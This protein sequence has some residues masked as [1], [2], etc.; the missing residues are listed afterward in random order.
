[1][2]GGLLFVSQALI[3]TWAAQGRIDFVG[4]V[5]TLLAGEGAGR[6]YELE[7]AVRFLKVLGVEK[8]PH[9]L[10]AKVKPLA[11]LRDL[12]AEA[13]ESSVI[14]GDVAYDVEQGFLAEASAIQAAVSAPIPSTPPPETPAGKAGHVEAGAPLASP[15]PSRPAGLPKDLEERRK[16]A[17]ALARFL[18]DN[19]S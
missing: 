15:A 5:M 1:M 6:R 2:A 17:E 11:Q 16:E 12:G 4:N 13:V 14:M 8:D 10:V 19:L 18:L 7:P 3:D 9:Q